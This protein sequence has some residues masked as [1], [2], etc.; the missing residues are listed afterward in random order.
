MEHSVCSLYKS[1]HCSVVKLF[2]FNVFKRKLKTHLFNIAY[3]TYAR[4]IPA[5]ANYILVTYGAL[6]VL[7]CIVLYCNVSVCCHSLLISVR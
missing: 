4:L 6:Q 7:Y 1:I 5:P 3:A 2:Y